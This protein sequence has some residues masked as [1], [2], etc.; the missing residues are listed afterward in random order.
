MLP[1]ILLLTIAVTTGCERK[2]NARQ[3]KAVA[4]A[5]EELNEL[6]REIRD[7]VREHGEVQGSSEDH[8]RRTDAILKK[9]A[10]SD[11]M[12]VRA[13]SNISSCEPCHFSHK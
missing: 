8:F 5:Q 3:A 1:Y 10:E 6:K 2:G 11:R 7:E 12:I 4:D 9:M 13:N